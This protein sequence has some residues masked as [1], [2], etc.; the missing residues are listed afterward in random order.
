MITE[1][2][3]F[4]A[5]NELKLYSYKVILDENVQKWLVSI[6]YGWE[7]DKYVFS[8]FARNRSLKTANSMVLAQMEERLSV[9]Q[10]TPVVSSNA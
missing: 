4:L 7:N 3:R 5:R 2:V 6:V 1:I 8:H 10:P 9:H